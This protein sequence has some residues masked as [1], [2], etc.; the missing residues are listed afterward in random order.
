[1]ESLLLRCQIFYGEADRL[2]GILMPKDLS[3][4]FKTIHKGTQCNNDCRKKKNL[5]QNF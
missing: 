3:F 1:M 5:V 4:A 2:Q